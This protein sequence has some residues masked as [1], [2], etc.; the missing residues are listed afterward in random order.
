ML[1]LNGCNTWKQENNI[2]CTDLFQQDDNSAMTETKR[3]DSKSSRSKGQEPE[4]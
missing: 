3:L 2:A 1:E 4:H